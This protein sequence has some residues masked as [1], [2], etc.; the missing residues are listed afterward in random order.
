MITLH[1]AEHKAYHNTVR[2][3]KNTIL[4]YS[5]KKSFDKNVKALSILQML[6]CCDD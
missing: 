3:K 1:S 2:D 6:N 4:P 5:L